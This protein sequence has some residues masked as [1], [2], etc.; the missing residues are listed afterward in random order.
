MVPSLPPVSAAVAAQGFHRFAPPNCR[1]TLA[2]RCRRLFCMLACA[3]MVD[4]LGGPGEKIREMLRGGCF[5]P[6]GGL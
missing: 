2:M 6:A 1:R 3:A 5:F 4:S